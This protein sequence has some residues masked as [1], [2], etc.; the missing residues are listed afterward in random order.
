[1][2]GYGPRRATR[3]NLVIGVGLVL[4]SVLSLVSVVTS[5]VSGPNLAGPSIVISG[6]TFLGGYE[7]GKY[8]ENRISKQQKSNNN[9]Q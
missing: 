5:S 8:V 7:I 2:S 9:V 6:L 3:V 1:M 4:L